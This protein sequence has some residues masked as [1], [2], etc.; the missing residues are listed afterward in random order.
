M[1]QRLDTYV[2]QKQYA[3]TRSQAENLIKLGSVEVNGV[4]IKKSGYQVSQVDKVS[5][6]KSQQYVSRAALKLESAMRAHPFDFNKKTVLDVGSSTGGFT[7]YVLQHGA[8]KVIAIDVG[9]AQLHPSLRQD[10]RIDLHEKTDIRDFKT[11]QAID[12]VLIDVSFISILKI[13]KA[14]RRLSQPGT[15]VIAM[16][17]PQF[18]AASQDQLNKGVVKNSRYRR[19]ILQ[20][21]EHKIK[22]YCQIISAVDSAVAGEKGNVERFYTLKFIR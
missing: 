6:R 5:V 3:R 4:V 11:K 21:F 15:V 9:S 7:D 13:I 22:E 1:K 20:N 12:V 14:V 18:E 19:A 8:K 10:E 17:K 16:V 2:L